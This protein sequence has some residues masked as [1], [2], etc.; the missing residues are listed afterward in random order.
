MPLTDTQKETLARNLTTIP[1][2][3]HQLRHQLTPT[4]TTH[5]TTS[6]PHQRAQPNPPLN[7]HT[8]DLLIT[9]E[10]TLG[11][12]WAQLRATLPQTHPTPHTNHTPKT[13]TTPTHTTQDPTTRYAHN[14][15]THRNQLAATPWAQ[16]AH[17]DIDQLAATLHHHTNPPTAEASPLTP[18][19]QAPAHTIARLATGYTGHPIN[20][21][22]I[23]YWGKAGYIPTHHS[24]G[25][26]THYQLQDV[27]NHIRNHH[28]N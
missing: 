19:Y 18:N 22:Q 5:N 20:R 10:Q 8:L 4:R 1:T 17:Q 12:Y 28:T 13:T 16:Q 25:G 21:K 7:L 9:T 27:I 24:P 14:L 6:T 23:T 26:P 3:T 11:H 15:Y 2:H